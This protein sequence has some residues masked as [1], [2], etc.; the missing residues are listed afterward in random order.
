MDIKTQILHTRI[1]TEG[2]LPNVTP[3]FQNSAFLTGSPFFYARK[4][5]PNCEELETVFRG[6]EGCQ[7]ATVTNSGMAAISLALRQLKPHDHVILNELV[8]G[9]T[10]RYFV[11]FCTHYKISLD[12]VDLT[13]PSWKEKL[14][15]RTRMVFFETPTNPLLKTLNI[16]E[17]SAATKAINPRALVCVDNTWATAFF[18]KP[19]NLGADIA[20]ASATK[21]YAGHS[22]CMAGV[23]TT[24]EKS[25]GEELARQRFYM[26]CHLDPHSAWLIRRSMQTFV[27]RMREHERVLKQMTVFL[28]DQAEIEKVYLPEVNK[29]QLTGYG[30]ILFI[31]LRPEFESKIESFMKSLQLFDRGTSMAAVVSSVAHPFSGS[32]ASMTAEE[33]LRV[34]IKNTLLRLCFGFESEEDLKA[35]L[36]QALDG[37]HEGT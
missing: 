14:N 5:N 11:D 18:Q 28:Q 8:Y 25:L 29:N 9:C 12:I 31:E 32:H 2:A 13:K 3:V 23:I 22:D 33:K 1:S 16:A 15:S 17:I 36:R 19:L 37:L 21:F 26:G 34:G 30:C 7:Y 35:D 20:I 27:L 6:L 24:N 4:N 10:Y